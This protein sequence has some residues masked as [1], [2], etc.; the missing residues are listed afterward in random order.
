MIA[1][2]LKLNVL[3]LIILYKNNNQ[4]ATTI[5]TPVVWLNDHSKKYNLYNKKYSNLKLLNEWYSFAHSFKY[6]KN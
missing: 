5:S 3:K 2:I 6:V 4:T 1:L